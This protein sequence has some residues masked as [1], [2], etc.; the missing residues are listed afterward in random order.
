MNQRRLDALSDSEVTANDEDSRY[1][2]N[3]E[4]LF[5]KTSFP[6]GGDRLDL[7]DGQVS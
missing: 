3:A 7:Y 2:H 6:L 4:V 5:A 1:W